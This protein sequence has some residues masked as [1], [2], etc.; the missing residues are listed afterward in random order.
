MELSSFVSVS[1]AEKKGTVPYSNVVVFDNVVKLIET[2]VLWHIYTVYSLF[3]YYVIQMT[4][5]S[6]VDCCM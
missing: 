3:K 5:V 4:T 6:N 1:V 2:Y